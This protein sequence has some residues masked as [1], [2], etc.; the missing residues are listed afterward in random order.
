MSEFKDFFIPIFTLVVGWYGNSLTGKKDNRQGD[1]EL[2][3]KLFKDIKR[4]DLE[5]KEVRDRLDKLEKENRVLRDSEYQLQ[6]VNNTLVVEN[7][8]LKETVEEK[9]IRELELLEVIEELKGDE[10]QHDFK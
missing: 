3:E 7:I 8:E 5:N 2:I 1:Q 4:I 9:E 10:Y 6:I